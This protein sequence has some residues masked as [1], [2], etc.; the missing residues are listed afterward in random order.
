MNQNEIDEKTGL[1]LDKSYLEVELP[2]YLEHSLNVWKEYLKRE[3]KGI[4][5]DL[6]DCYWCELNADIN[7]A[8]VEQEITTE[9]AWHLRI[10]YLGMERV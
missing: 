1:P 9:Q 6:W 5:D 3:E 4:K 8:E 2:W 10:K 7:S